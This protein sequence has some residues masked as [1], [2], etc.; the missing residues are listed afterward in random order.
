MKKLLAIIC[1]LLVI[2]V[3]MYVYKNNINQN[4]VNVSEIEKI[5]EYIS[6]IYMW[7][8][9]TE[10]ALPKFDNINNAPDLWVWEVVKKNLEEFE[11]DY[12]QI[13]EKAIEI[14]GDNFTKQFP[15]EGS[16]YIYYDKNYGKYITTGIGLDT[17]DDMFYI[18]KINKTKVGYEVEI[19]EYLEDYEN[20]MGLEDE[21]EV[22]DIYIKNIDQETVATIKSNESETR[23]I[24]V[25][26]ENI[27]KFTT[28]T[29]NLVKDSEENIFVESVK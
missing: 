6:K 5:E 26:K 18:K 21:N 17:Q 3:G 28:K 10:E 25:V 9:V 19:V 8:E 24:E 16:E 12:N 22:Y 7:Q 2:F 14:F 13:Q 11:L 1:V 20:S 27:D 23:A 4:T 29:I 15:K